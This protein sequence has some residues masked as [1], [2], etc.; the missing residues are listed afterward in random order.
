[1]VQNGDIKSHLEFSIS[2]AILK[3][4][5]IPNCFVS[6]YYTAREISNEICS[7]YVVMGV[8]EEMVLLK[9]KL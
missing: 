4:S 3:G 6:R 8:L 7:F 9:Q 5:H 1:M 2:I